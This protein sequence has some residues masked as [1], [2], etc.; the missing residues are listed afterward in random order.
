[1]AGYY[2]RLEA[3]LAR[4]TARGAAGRA[5]WRLRLPRIRM[6]VVAGA[7][8]VAAVVAVVAVFVGLDTPRR[9]ARTVVSPPL[10][11]AV[12]R[13]RSGPEVIR[14]YAP[15]PAPALGGQMVCDAALQPPPGG[16]SRSGTVIVNSRPPNRFAFSI[17]ASGLPPT[18]HGKGYA[19]WIVPA[20]RT[21]SGAYELP[22]GASAGRGLSRYAELVGVIK[23]G[24]ANG[25]VSAEGLM[26]TDASGAELLILTL[27]GRIPTR[28]FLEGYIEF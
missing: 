21:T 19:V 24:P 7:L 25:K 8:G 9:L 17:T 26:P 27:P 28:I 22:G 15:G 4:A 12:K 5:A 2:D 23:P 6:N 11:S 18:D 10:G 13:G 16:G 3:Q 20:V 1:M 14:N